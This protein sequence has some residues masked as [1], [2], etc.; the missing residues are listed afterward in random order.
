MRSAASLITSTDRRAAT[1]RGASAGCPKCAACVE[2]CATRNSACRGSA[3]T[4][5]FACIRHICPLPVHAGHVTRRPPVGLR[6]A[7]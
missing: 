5:F 4:P 6:M 2:R 1:R 3:K 7:A